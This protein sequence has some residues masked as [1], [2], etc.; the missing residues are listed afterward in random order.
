MDAINK[1]RLLRETFAARLARGLNADDYA[2][3]CADPE[4]PS[5]FERALSESRPTLTVLADPLN[6]PE[7]GE[8]SELG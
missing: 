8:P 6:M 5:L 1:D 3:I 7:P 4:Q 2:A